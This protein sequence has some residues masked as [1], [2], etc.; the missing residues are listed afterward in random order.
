MIAV[1]REVRIPI[2]SE[3]DILVARQQ[4]R[5]M[6]ADLDFAITDQ[7]ATATAISELSRNIVEYAK[8]GEVV[9]SL[10]AKG[11]RRGIMIVARDDGPGIPDVERVLQGGYST[12]GGLGLGVSGTRRLMDEF[13]IASVVGKGTIVTARKWQR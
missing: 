9:L 5:Q 3:V 10:I 1:V 13:E 6:A 8:A 2:R 11:D 4:G 7:V 12:S